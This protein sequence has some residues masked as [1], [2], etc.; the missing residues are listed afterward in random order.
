MCAAAQ[1]RGSCDCTASAC[2][3]ERDK[4]RCCD[5]F[6]VCI[7][8]GESMCPM[9]KSCSCCTPL[10]SGACMAHCFQSSVPCVHGAIF[11]AQRQDAT[12]LSLVRLNFRTHTVYSLVSRCRALQIL[13]FPCNQ[14]GALEPGSNAQIKAAVRNTYNA[15]FPLFSKV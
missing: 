6:W 14:F 15:T 11:C 12:L 1:C 7:T 8:F 5:M 10:H 13:A 4:H 3:H 2:I 9:S